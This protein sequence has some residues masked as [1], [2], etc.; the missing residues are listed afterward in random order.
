M[1]KTELRGGHVFIEREIDDI[2]TWAYIPRN[3]DLEIE[4]RSLSKYGLPNFFITAD[5]KVISLKTKRILKQTIN[6][7]G[8]YTISTYPEGRGSKAVCYRVHRLLAMEFVSNPDNK[9]FVNHKDGKKL[10]NSISNLEWVTNQENTT[11]AHSTGLCN[12]YYTEY[13]VIDLTS[14]RRFTMLRTSTLEKLLGIT[15]KAVQKSI[16]KY[17][18]NNKYVIYNGYIFRPK[19]DEPWDLSNVVRRK[20]SRRIVLIRKSDRSLHCFDC[21]EQAVNFLGREIELDYK[22]VAELDD[23]YIHKQ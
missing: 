7:N 21:L 23:W 5:S 11:H 9:P 14:G 17:A 4:A 19:S 16:S 1:I 22:D 20:L 13:D 18:N 12:G 15:K 10:N 2:S 3:T 8:Y 6:K